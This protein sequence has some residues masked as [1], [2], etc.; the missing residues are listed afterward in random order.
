MI[1]AATGVHRW[2]RRRGGVAAR[3]AGAAAGF[4]NA[5]SADD[6]Y[7]NVTVPFL[8]GLK[9]TGRKYGTGDRAI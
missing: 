4:L 3:G 8:Q 6:D 9:E 2:A 5:E 7:K 1:V